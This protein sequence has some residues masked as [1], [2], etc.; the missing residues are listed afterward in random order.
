MSE[1]NIILDPAERDFA[2]FMAQKS[3]LI[4]ATKRA[5][6]AQMDIARKADAAVARLES[7]LDNLLG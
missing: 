2:N 7:Q 6:K 4:E 1:S 3:D 5:I